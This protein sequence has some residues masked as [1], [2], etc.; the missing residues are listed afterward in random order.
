MG[1]GFCPYRLGS[2]QVSATVEIHA[3]PKI[4]RIA[5]TANHVAV[6]LGHRHS[7]LLSVCDLEA[8]RESDV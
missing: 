3:E 4:L 2:I 5:G 1:V 7:L 8:G 6:S